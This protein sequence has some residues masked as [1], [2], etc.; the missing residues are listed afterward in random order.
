MGITTILTG[1]LL[2]VTGLMYSMM[3]LT[4]HNS[5]REGLKFKVQET[6]DKD[7]N[8]I[9]NIEEMISVFDIVHADANKRLH[10][11]GFYLT[12]VEMQQYLKTRGNYDPNTDL[13]YNIFSKD[14]TYFT[15]ALVE[16]K[17]VHRV[18]F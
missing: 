6:A 2:V 16:G 17:P 9:L 7:K 3:D 11:S 12:E 13:G 1:G 14:H 4:V 18:Q 8:G 10:D 15:K 5:F